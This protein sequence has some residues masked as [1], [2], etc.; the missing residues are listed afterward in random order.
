MLV[1]ASSG[2]ASSAL[3]RRTRSFSGSGSPSG[4]ASHRSS[5]A[6]G[7]VDGAGS[8]AKLGRFTVKR[9]GGG[10]PETCAVCL[11]DFGGGA[12]P[13]RV[14]RLGCGHAFCAPCLARCAAHDLARCP[15]CRREHCLDPQELER[16]LGEPPR[17]K[18]FRKPGP[19]EGGPPCAGAMQGAGIPS[20]RRRVPR[21]LPGLA[22]RRGLWRA[23]RARRR[24]EGAGS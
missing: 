9:G 18:M 19:W 12:R 2:P 21:R 8:V 14:V 4:T 5:S 7:V 17:P 16:R 11:C 23:R 20:P 3:H 15:V 22:A 1:A 24:Q 10:A 6:D 13:G